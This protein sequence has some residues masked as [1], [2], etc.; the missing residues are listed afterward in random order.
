MW[1]AAALQQFERCS[2]AL[3]GELGVRPDAA[4]LAL[5]ERIRRD[6]RER[7]A[8]AVLDMTS[9]Q[10]L[11]NL[12]VPTTPFVGRAEELAQITSLL[13]DPACRLLTLIGIGGVGKTRLAL[14]VAHTLVAGRHATESGSAFQHGV[15]F[16]PLAPINTAD[17][18]IAAIASAMRFTFSGQQEIKAQLLSHL[19]VKDVL[20]VLDNFEHL[21]REAPL[22]TEVLQAAGGVKLLVTSRE[23]LD[24]YEEWLFDV[25]GLS[26]PSADATS[27]AA[28]TTE[29]DDALTKYSAVQL[30][31]QRAR[32]LSSRFDLAD[33]P[34]V[35]AGICRLMEGLP[36][37]IELA[38]G[39]VRTHTCDEIARAIQRNLDFLS[40]SAQNVPERHRSLRV[41]FDY[42]WDMLTKEEAHKLAGLAVFRDGFDD[43]AARAVAGAT[44][45]DL[46]RLADKSLLQR[47]SDERWHVHEMLRRYLA[48]RL[49]PA[50]WA[51][52]QAAHGRFYAEFVAQRAQAK[53]RR[54]PNLGRWASCARRSA[55]CARRG[56]G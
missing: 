35:V 4:T 12:P 5:A 43:A 31:A 9:A 38:A 33:E 26:F 3:A 16:V 21:T 53:K 14:Q 23:R 17:Q 45:A 49:T 15:Y 20:L 28:S 56:H 37:G 42:S 46:D 24:L 55:T 27:D 41:A 10:A 11:H 8:H 6:M 22:L 51:G 52:V 44:R 39:W 30:F 2:R 36:L 7:D 32:R 1:P 48:G 19:R 18:M 34:Q 54:P 29:G 47:A 50:Q 25:G 13:A 40:T